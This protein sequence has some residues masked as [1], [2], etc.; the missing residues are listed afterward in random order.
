MT[1]ERKTFE[2]RV[3]VYATEERARELIEQIKLLL[4]PEPEHRSPCPVPWAIGLLSEDEF[5]ADLS[6]AELREQY[7]I[8]R[9]LGL[10]GTDSTSSTRVRRQSG[11]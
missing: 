10:R 7:L 3:G 1:D 5:P 4:C 11:Q 2:I 9:G 8:E 6:Y